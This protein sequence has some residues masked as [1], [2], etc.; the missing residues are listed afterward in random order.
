MMQ[1]KKVLLRGKNPHNE[2]TRMSLE[3]WFRVDVTE[4]GTGTSFCT[5]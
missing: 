2:W 1:L 5:I 3:N 4:T